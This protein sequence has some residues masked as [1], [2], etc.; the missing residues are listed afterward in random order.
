VPCTFRKEKQ[1]EVSSDL[2]KRRKRVLTCFIINVFLAR[3]MTIS[4]ATAGENGNRVFLIC[5]T[6]N[7]DVCIDVIRKILLADL[8]ERIRKRI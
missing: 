4:K 6:H 2:E 1:E 8:Y 5:H 7:G 3:G